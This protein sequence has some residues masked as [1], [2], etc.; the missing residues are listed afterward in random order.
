MN[1]YND[2]LRT[3]VITALQ[4]QEL[5]L[6]QV[7]AQYNAAMFT[8]Y[9][10]QGAEITASE[11]V[12]AAQRD[13]DNF[14]APLKNQAVDNSNIA[15]NLILSAGQAGTYVKQ[16]VTNTAVSASNVQIAAN[17]IIKL[18]SDVGAIYSIVN[19]ADFDTNIYALAKKAYNVINDTAYN[20]ELVSQ[21]SMEASMRT[22]E[23][24]VST[25][26][27]KAKIVKAGMDNILKITSTDF[28]NASE[29]VRNASVNL[30]DV[31]AKEKLAE[32]AFSDVNVEYAAS[33]RAYKAINN[34]LNLNLTVTFPDPLVQNL[35][36]TVA[37]DMVQVPF[38]IEMINILP[39]PS[40]P[41]PMSTYYIMV[42]KES[43]KSIF[44]LSVAEN[45]Q[46]LQGNNF[47]AVDQ[48]SI[49]GYTAKQA[50]TI[51][52]LN[53]TD[54]DALVP[55]T[56]YVVFV[57][58]IYQDGYKKDVNDFDEFLSAPSAPFVMTTVLTS[59]DSGDINVERLAE[60]DNP[61]ADKNATE[62]LSF[63]IAP[64]L[65]IPVQY[66]CMF[67]PEEKM[68][69]SSLI[70]KALITVKGQAEAEK[71]VDAMKN[72]VLEYD[73]QIAELESRI[74]MLSIQAQLDG[75]DTTQKTAANTTATTQTV[76]VDGNPP[77]TDTAP[78]AVAG[79]TPAAPGPV[80]N[81]PAGNLAPT[82][83]SIDSLTQQ[84][85]QIKAEKEAAKLVLDTTEEDK[86]GFFF[87]VT[88]AEGVLAGNYSI[89]TIADGGKENETA[90]QSYQVY[91]D[92][93]V[94][95]NFGNLLVDGISYIPV[96]LSIYQG[97]TEVNDD[98]YTSTI[99]D[100]ENTESFVYYA[101]KE[102]PVV[103]PANTSNQ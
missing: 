81:R 45:I 30:S 9:Y 42:V 21:T 73:P 46:M 62:L 19:A 68:L 33:R 71:Q 23:V 4:S 10:A 47:I 24:S 50:I 103:E 5:E 87:N 3:G 99:S 39:L 90:Q 6:K 78:A 51:N 15:N 66:R 35:G 72:I 96:I 2:N 100:Y 52:E 69:T 27:D 37:F 28:D 61:P 36:F 67:L 82:G 65:N 31:S 41:Y 7:Q 93:S 58:G 63:S 25:V 76:P 98:Q 92:S 83:D 1:S 85:E 80:D 14:K 101:E 55:G 20:A 22:S 74:N 79:D 91:I 16:A 49:D 102:K 97:N 77:A 44:S 54:N 17:A 8:L 84:L 29:M 60:G 95:D 59:V 11:K 64:Q 43:K 88:L 40:A 13:L 26:V 89:A 70:K 75:G 94:T 86:V 34:Q 32:G 57:Y 38:P 56:S 18:A 12:L 48:A 53:D